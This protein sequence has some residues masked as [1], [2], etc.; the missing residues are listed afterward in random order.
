MQS[1][2]STNL[3][4]LLW[5]LILWLSLQKFSYS[6][7]HTMIYP[8]FQKEQKSTKDSSCAF[9]CNRTENEGSP[10]CCP[11]PIRM[12]RSSG[13]GQ[14]RPSNSTPLGG[15][16]CPIRSGSIDRTN[17]RVLWGK[18]HERSIYHILLLLIL[19]F[20]MQYSIQCV[21]CA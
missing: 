16:T 18:R 6:S 9:P 11:S 3:Q 1:E 20:S 4:P 10:G 21:L 15:R 12:R 8:R 13:D 2:W 7:S 17:E 14:H 5:R 19:S